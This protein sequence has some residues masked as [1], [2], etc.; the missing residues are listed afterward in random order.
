MTPYLESE[1]PFEP[2]PQGKRGMGFDPLQS[3]REDSIY[4][5]IA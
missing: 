2:L 3:S 5:H 4:R 1:Q